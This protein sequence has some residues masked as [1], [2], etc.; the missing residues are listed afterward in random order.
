[1]RNLF[2]A[3][4]STLAVTACLPGVSVTA[5]AMA[6]EASTLIDLRQAPQLWADAATAGD[7]AELLKL[8]S[9]EAFVHVVFTEDELHG[10]EEIGGYYAQ[11]EKNPPKVTIVRIDEA[12]NFGGVGVLSG[13]ARVEFHEQEPMMTHFSTVLKIEDGQWAIQ[14][15][16]IARI[17]SN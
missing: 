12:E 9:K 4:L 16:H 13:L 10:H 14:L 11:Y 7:T 2:V 5:P 17:D 1:M 6:A 8:Y 15:Q 3:L